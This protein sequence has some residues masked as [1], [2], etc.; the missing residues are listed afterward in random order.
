M[1]M[2]EKM[3]GKRADDGRICRA[4]IRGGVR[5]IDA[6]SFAYFMAS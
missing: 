4:F 5:G 2:D 1:L 3:E 6:L